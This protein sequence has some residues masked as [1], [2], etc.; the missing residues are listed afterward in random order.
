[1]SVERKPYADI[2][3]LERPAST[4]PHMALQDRA[5]QFLPFAA[6]TG[7]EEAIAEAGRLT[8]ERP[9][10]DEGQRAVLDAKLHILREHSA[11]C[12]EVKITWFA[13]DERKAGGAYR[14][15]SGIIK[16]I[17][18]YKR[19]IVM[20]DGTEIEV[21]SIVDIDSMTANADLFRCWDS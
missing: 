16:K 6:L 21:D 18:D 1:M 9:E 19:A 5:A 8:M 14:I 17:D 13:A 11:E 20:A 15:T 7:Y 4:H 12:P 2:L 10:E 3:H